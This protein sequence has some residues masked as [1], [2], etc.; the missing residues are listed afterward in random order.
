MYA[1]ALV[2]PGSGH[3]AWGVSTC[4]GTALTKSRRHHLGIVPK[5]TPPTTVSGP[6]SAAVRGQVARCDLPLSLR[7]S[8]GCWEFLAAGHGCEAARTILDAAVEQVAEG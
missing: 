7:T 8:V 4:D 6:L 5:S 1:R 2:D 3:A